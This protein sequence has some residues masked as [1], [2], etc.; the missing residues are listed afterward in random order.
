MVL[1]LYCFI[2][3]LVMENSPDN[4]VP[5]QCHVQGSVR[6]YKDEEIILSTYFWPWAMTALIIIFSYKSK[7]L[8]TYSYGSNDFIGLGRYSK[9]V[10]SL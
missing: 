2:V 10:L 5:V 9:N 8:R 3:V 7:L 1:F 6:T 4:I